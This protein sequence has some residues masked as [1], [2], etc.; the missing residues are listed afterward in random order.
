MFVYYDSY[1]DDYSIYDYSGRWLAS[2][3]Y[4]SDAYDWLDFISCE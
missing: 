4:A 3:Y 1:Y 2:F